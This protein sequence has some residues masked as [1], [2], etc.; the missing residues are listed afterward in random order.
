[1]YFNK[2]LMGSLMNYNERILSHKMSKKLD[3]N[4]VKNVSATGGS[5]NYYFTHAATGNANGHESCMD[6]EVDR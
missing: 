4:Q 2:N 6:L 3:F 5:L 1:M